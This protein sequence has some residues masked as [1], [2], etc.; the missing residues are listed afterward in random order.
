MTRPA[1]TR[2]PENQG[3][4]GAQLRRRRQPVSRTNAGDG[5]GALRGARHGDVSG[6]VLVGRN[7]LPDEAQRKPFDG[8]LSR[9]RE[10]RNR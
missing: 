5:Q 6:T 2:L 1:A 10:D 7:L 9:E 4:I 3:F 8:G